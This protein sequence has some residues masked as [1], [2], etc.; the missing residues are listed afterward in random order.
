MIPSKTTKNTWYCFNCNF[1][2]FNS[3]LICDKCLAQKPIKKMRDFES[4]EYDPAF[5]KEVCDYF[6]QQQL[7]K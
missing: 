4:Y 3:K 2:I 5:N 7:K 1:H 6:I